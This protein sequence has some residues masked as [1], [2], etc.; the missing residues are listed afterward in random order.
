MIDIDPAR[1]PLPPEV[2]SWD[3]ER[4]ASALRHEPGV[5]EYDPGF[6]QLLHVG[7]KVAAE[8]GEKFLD[9]VSQHKEIVAGQVTDNI[10][11]RHI[12][13]LF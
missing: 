9:M 10:Y 5:P 1:L 8:M 13:R 3:G 2:D 4:F 6:R 12:K 11:E 7:Y